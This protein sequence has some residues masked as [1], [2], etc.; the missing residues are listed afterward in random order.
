[1]TF[2]KR[3]VI[4]TLAIIL[5][6][7]LLAILFTMLSNSDIGTDSSTTSSPEEEQVSYVRFPIHRGNMISTY[8][9]VATA[10]MSEV[11][12]SE[13]WLNSDD[14]VVV[15]RGADVKKGETLYKKGDETVNATCNMKI[16]N[17][18]YDTE[19]DK[20]IVEYLNYESIRLTAV[21]P[22]SMYDQVEYKSEITTHNGIDEIQIIIEEIGYMVEN[23]QFEIVLS[24]DLFILPGE[25]IDCILK[26]GVKENVLFIPAEAVFD[27]GTSNY[28]V[29]M[30]DAYKKPYKRDIYIGELFSVNEN[31]NLYYYYEVLGGIDEGEIAVVPELDTEYI[32]YE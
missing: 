24:S 17:I 1:M 20:Q 21:L 25:K 26:R 10:S 3:T 32:G 9:F 22:Y 31:G 23:N 6:V 7:G 28:Y 8:S 11:S 13:L 4:T 18:R 15:K 19:S 27:D 2:L 5:I 16:L 30:L 12:V 14:I 29:T